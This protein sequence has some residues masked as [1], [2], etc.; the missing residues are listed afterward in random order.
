M[1]TPRRLPSDAISQFDQWAAAVFDQSSLGMIRVYPD[2]RIAAWNQ[3][4]AETLGLATLEG[5]SADELLADPPSIET[6]RRQGEQRRQGLSTEFEI[7]VF[8]FP[9]GRPVPVQ[10]SAMPMIS[11]TDSRP[12]EMAQTCSTTSARVKRAE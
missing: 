12:P 2:L 3:T 9:E 4:V 6:M 11:F 7:N 8:H 1:S 10:V 5:R